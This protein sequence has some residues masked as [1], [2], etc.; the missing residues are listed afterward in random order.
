VHFLSLVSANVTQLIVSKNISGVS[1]WNVPTQ[2]YMSVLRPQREREALKL[3]HGEVT[4]VNAAKYLGVMFDQG[5]NWREQHAYV[6]TKGS[7][8]TTQIRRAARPT[9]GITPKYNHRLY[10]GVTLPRIL[11]G[12]DVW[13]LPARRTHRGPKSGA[14]AKAVKQLTSVQRAGALAIRG[15]L[16]TSLTDA[17]NVCTLIPPA[18]QTLEKAC[19]RALV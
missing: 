18:P 9:C 12:E 14:S 11:Y 15:G 2:C 19:F 3:P 5:L 17:L 6:T 16:R 8:W 4:T 7:T 1:S 13:C 10:I